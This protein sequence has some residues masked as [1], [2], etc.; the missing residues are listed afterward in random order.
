MSGEVTV[1]ILLAVILG[2]LILIRRYK[3]KHPKKHAETRAQPPLVGLMLKNL[4][5]ARA[6][7]TGATSYEFSKLLSSALKAYVRGAYKIPSSGVT[8]DEMVNRLLSDARNDWSI[9][10]LFT[11]VI[12]LTDAVKY[13]QR[14]LSQMQ[15]R[16]IYI[17]ACRFVLL[18]E[19]FF[20]ARKLSATSKFSRQAQGSKSPQRFT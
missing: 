7:M 19:R 5:L 9:V 20:R 16:G 3:I 10:G 2:I 12:K 1:I 17:K 11:E 8:S 4:R 15:Q 18:S 14:K 13:S 6:Q